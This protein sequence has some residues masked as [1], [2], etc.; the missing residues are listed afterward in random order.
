MLK[1]KGASSLPRQIA[2]PSLRDRLVLKTAAQYLRSSFPKVTHF[3]PQTLIGEVRAALRSGNYTDYVRLDI[4]NFYASI[5]HETIRRVLK[6]QGLPAKFVKLVVDAVENA[7]LADGPSPKPLTKNTRGVHAGLSLANTLG[8]IV[9]QEFDAKFLKMKDIKYVRYVDDVLIL[10]RHGERSAIQQ[11]AKTKLTELGL[12]AHKS[13]KAGKSGAG[14]ILT[15]GIDY[16]GYL[17]FADRITVSH[18]RTVRLAN[19]IARP[20]ALYRHSINEKRKVRDARERAIWWVN[21]TVTGCVA[22]EKRRGWLP[23][24]SQ[25]DD[26]SV[27]MGLDHMVE[28]MISRLAP[29][30]RFVPKKFQTAYTL[31]RNP[32]RDVH[33]Y[34]PDFDKASYREKRRI[35]AVASKYGK[36][37]RDTQGVDRMFHRFIGIA[38]ASLETDVGGLS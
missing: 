12:S 23:Y 8:E 10:C 35:L 32:A 19:S 28:K 13:G 27:L 38:V 25:I 5:P 3:R 29:A 26:M 21:L 9:L 22:N 37:P 18:S 30:D 11:I 1:L 16:L 36:I 6:R 24:Y 14:K 2:I 34:I 4:V 15:D 31:T 33:G 20:I 7:T 17:L